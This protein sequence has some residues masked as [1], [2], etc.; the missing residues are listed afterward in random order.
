MCSRGFLL[1][2]DKPAKA[3]DCARNYFADCHALKRWFKHISNWVP[4]NSL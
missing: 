2:A 3:E 1:A 4:L